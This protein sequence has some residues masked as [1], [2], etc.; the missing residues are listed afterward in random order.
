MHMGKVRLGDFITLL[1][2]PYHM[3]ANWSTVGDSQIIFIHRVLQEFITIVLFP[4][5]L[6]Y[7]THLHPCLKN[8][9]FWHCKLPQ[10]LKS[11]KLLR[12]V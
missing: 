10:L 9:I 4:G 6:H 5:K 2:C 8:V 3:K 12:K 11:N 7:H 1:Y